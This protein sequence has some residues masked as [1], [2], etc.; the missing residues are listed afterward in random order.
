MGGINQYISNK[1]NTQEKEEN[2]SYKEKGI[3]SKLQFKT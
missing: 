2:E 1:P 3:I